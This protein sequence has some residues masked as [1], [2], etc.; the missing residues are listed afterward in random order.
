VVVTQVTELIAQQ[1]AAGANKQKV[2][3]TLIYNVKDIMYG[4]VGDG[5][6]DDTAAIQKA[7]NDAVANNATLVFFPPGSYKVTALTNTSTIHFVGDNAT[8]VGYSGTITPFGL[9]AQDLA[10]LKDVDL[11][12]PPTD[13]QFLAY[14]SASSKWKP[15]SLPPTFINVRDPAY[16]A[17][18]D[19]VTN[20]APAFQAAV[21]AMTNGSV[22]YIP[23]GDYLFTGTGPELLL[24][25]KAISMIGSGDASRIIIGPS[26]PSTTDII[27]VVPV[28]GVNTSLM[29]F[30]NFR[31]WSCSATISYGRHAIHLD[32]TDPN[33]HINNLMIERIDVFNVGGNA[34][35]LTNPTGTDA[36][37]AST[38]Q[39]SMLKGGIN[40]ERSGDSNNILRNLITGSNPGITMST[41]PGSAIT[42]IE[43]NNITAQGGAIS[44]TGA[45]QIQIRNNQIEQTLTYNSDKDAN[46]YLKDCDT[47]QVV[48]NNLNAHNLVSFNIRLAGNCN[49]IL[50]DGNYMYQPKLQH[51]AMDSNTVIGT[52]IGKNGRF[53]DVNLIEKDFPIVLNNGVKTVGVPVSITLG[54]GVTN[55]DTVNFWPAS[56]KKYPDGHCELYG[57]VNV[58]NTTSGANVATIPAGYRPITK[59]KYVVASSFAGTTPG[60]TTLAIDPTGNLN[61]AFAPSGTTRINLDGVQYATE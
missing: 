30:G 13:G 44:I 14:N 34:I 16:G 7:I 50:I 21:N 5:V 33:A 19:G 17:K 43:G 37:Y 1:M 25:T 8:F 24:I 12:V 35:K 2:W 18:G 53:F 6:T 4:A 28:S 26:V 48:G 42:I 3:G 61:I 36:F 54:T 49:N 41:V 15:K 11:S 22:L 59:S 47:C 60:A 23:P 39:D 55:A 9:G 52:V 31:I 20:D 32:C 57:S 10:A 38:I 46:V 45:N 40:L 27:H 56:V 29:Y 58:T 51:V